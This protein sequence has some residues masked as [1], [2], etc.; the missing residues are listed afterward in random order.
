[1]RIYGE[2]LAID[3][4]IVRDARNTFD[5]YSLEISLG[6]HGSFCPTQRILMATRAGELGRQNFHECLRRVQDMPEVR[7]FLMRVVE[8]LRQRDSVP[9]FVGPTTIL[10]NQPNYFEWL[11]NGS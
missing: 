5:G 11:R 10:G 6:Y 1:M 2:F 7:R 4:N 3:Y 9:R 8:D